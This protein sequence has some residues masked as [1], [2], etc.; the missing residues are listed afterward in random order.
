MNNLFSEAFEFE[1]LYQPNQ[2]FLR[3]FY[4]FASR[5]NSLQRH[6]EFSRQ[7]IARYLTDLQV[8][9]TD[10]SGEMNFRKDELVLSDQEYFPDFLRCAVV[11]QSLALVEN[12]LADVVHEIATKPGADTKLDERKMPYVNRTILFLTRNCGLE[13]E[14]GNDFWKNLDAIRELRNRYMHK[15]DRDLPDQIKATLTRIADELQS[16]DKPVNDAFVDVGLNLVAELAEKVE[17]AYW[18]WFDKQEGH[19]RI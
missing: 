3:A 13:I 6:W 4:E 18:Q 7:F 2:R 19:P 1:P 12:L 14:V 16:N 5:L 8:G 9:Q 10:G 17:T 15:L 11:S